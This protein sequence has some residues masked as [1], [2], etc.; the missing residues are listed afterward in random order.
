MFKIREANGQDLPAILSL[1]NKQA[2]TGKLLKRT[3]KD[4]RKV[5]RSFLVAEDNGEVVGCGALEVYNKKLAEIRSL[6]VLPSHQRKGIAR[7][8]IKRMIE[9][10]QKKEIY[11]ILAITDRDSV[12]SS[13][14]FAQ[15][16]HGQKALFLRP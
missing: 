1:I 13:H 10:A 11:E 4:V 6:V 7:S 5:L 8:L 15:Q 2:H 12:F 16:L 9:I 3:R 14:G